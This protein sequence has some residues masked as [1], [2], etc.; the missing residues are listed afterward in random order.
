MIRFRD[1]ETTY[2]N[3]LDDIEGEGFHIKSHESIGEDVFVLEIPDYQ[4]KKLTETLDNPEKL[5]GIKQYASI[6]TE[7]MK[8][9]FEAAVRFF[10]EN[11]HF[12]D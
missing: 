11:L 3:T 5:N 2:Q 6:G 8:S 4:D 1:P 7:P 12:Y 10:K 9:S